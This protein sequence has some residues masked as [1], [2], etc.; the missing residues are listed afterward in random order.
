M[1]CSEHART[2]EL[3]VSL[4]ERLF[5]RPL[6]ASSKAKASQSYLPSLSLP[7]SASAS[8]GNSSNVPSIGHVS[9][10]G[11]SASASSYPHD[12]NLPSTSSLIVN[13]TFNTS[14]YRPYTNLV[15]VSV[16]SLVVMFA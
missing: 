13:S 10:I 6:Y 11:S 3:D 14:S 8:V 9:S 16:L 5:E 1:I 15:K 12:H 4:L 7:V 2:G